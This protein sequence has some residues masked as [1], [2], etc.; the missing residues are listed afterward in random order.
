MMNNFRE[1]FFKYS[2]LQQTQEKYKKAK[3]IVKKTSNKYNKFYVAYSGGKDSLC[4]TH[5]VLQRFPDT[6]ILHWDFGKYYIP[7]NIREE[8]IANLKKI[9]GK[10]IRIETSEEYDKLKRQAINVLGKEMIEKLLPQL[11]SEGYDVSFIGLRK[12]E[13]RKRKRRIEAQRNCSAIKEIYPLQDW[14]WLDVWGYIVS[15]S[16]PYLS[17]YDK[18]APVVGWDK[19]RFTTLFDPEFDKYGCSNIDGILNWSFKHYEY[20]RRKIIAN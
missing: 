7:D 1:T 2:Q 16:L 18:Y 20:E 17:H 19:A 8:I 6:M 15:N 10:N 9:G 13:S 3:E 11:R 12:E 4:M 5:L 14:S